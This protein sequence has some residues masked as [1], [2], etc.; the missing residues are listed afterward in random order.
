MRVT[1]ERIPNSNTLQKEIA[2]PIGIIVK[3]YGDSITVKIQHMIIFVRV[4]RHQQ[5][6]LD[7]NQL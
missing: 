6:V 3:P 2:L 5:L 7:R 1:T 4:R